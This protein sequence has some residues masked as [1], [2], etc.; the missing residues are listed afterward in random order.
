MDSR[1]ELLMEATT[2]QA[3]SLSGSAARQ[4][5]GW[6]ERN[7]TVIMSAGML[8]S[9][10]LGLLLA[11]LIAVAARWILL[12][13]FNLD[14]SIWLGPTALIM[15][16]LFIIRH[17]YPG[18]GLGAV[19]E[20][21]SLTIGISL[22]FI[23]V[24]F[25]MVVLREE[26]TISRFVFGTFWLT[27]IVII[28]ASRRLMRH[29]MTQWKLWGEPTVIIGQQ[30]P[31]LKLYKSLKKDPK[32]G[33]KPVAILTPKIE[34]A[35][36]DVPVYPIEY[37]AEF[38]QNSRVRMAAVIYNSMDELGSIAAYY[39]ED[40][41]RLALFSANGNHHFLNK[42]S[43]RQ[44]GS[45]VSL[46]VHHRLLDPWAQ[47]FKR[48]V[49]VILSTSAILLLSPLFLVMALLIRLDSTGPVFYRQVR[50]GKRGRSFTLFKFRT[51]YQ[52]ADQL[53]AATLARDA[54]QK[55][56]WD[57]YQKLKCDPRITRAGRLIR[58]FSL[59]ELAQLWNVLR[60]EMSL[61]GP[62]PLMPFQQQIYG[63]QYQ[64]YVRVLPGI[65]GLWQIN[66][67]NHTSFNRR[68]D[69]DMEYVIT[70]SIWLDIYIMVRTVWV[71]LRRDGAF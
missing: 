27:S 68:A 19:E 34:G 36:G 17:L 67:R 60:G 18:I 42:V 52:E 2:T 9:D 6:A 59:D 35:E 20:F 21:R 40:F 49:D 12:G 39:R 66:G 16:I 10:L 69:F 5:Q 51:M 46:D 11:G 38:C 56:E 32:I 31:A 3:G 70:W 65:S 24:S 53:L 57:T 61:V 45:L 1:G 14:L 22:T 41:E 13:P 30:E 43:I 29:G 58:R 48:I 63:P 37:K 8:A 55:Q 4:S 50:L 44:Y 28:P 64:H 33:L 25:S 15:V 47:A 26:A 7:A 62:R 71:V 54:S 23:I